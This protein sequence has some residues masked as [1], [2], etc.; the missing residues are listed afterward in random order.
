[1]DR[2]A[3]IGRNKIFKD[4][5]WG[6][7][8]RGIA[9]L[10][11]DKVTYT[12]RDELANVTDFT[13]I[14]EYERPR[15]RRFGYWANTHCWTPRGFSCLVTAR[16][17]PWP[18]VSRP[19]NRPSPG[20]SC[21]PAP[22]SRCTTRWCV[23]FVTSQP[24][25]SPGGRPRRRSGRPDDHPAVR[26]DRQPRLLPIHT[27]P[28]VATGIPAPY[29]LDLRT[30]D[31]VAVAAQLDKPMRIVQGGRDY[32]VTVADD[33]IRWQTG[34][35]DHRDVTIRIYQVDNHLFFSGSGPSTAAEYEPAQHVDEAVVTDI[36]KWVN[37]ART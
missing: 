16:A 32:Q 37:S 15:S 5:A 34:L 21:W 3:T 1:M 10:R 14:D 19:R 23:S 6:L 22:H 13:V 35:A 12:H 36:A 17:P 7:A 20:W 2:D 9:V 8:S 31:P 25:A 24:L 28:S 11:F 27:R 18:H 26:A 4:L 30:Y 33:L 29:W